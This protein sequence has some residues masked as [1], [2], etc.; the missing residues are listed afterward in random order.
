MSARRCSSPVARYVPSVNMS[1]VR[2][3][4]GIRKFIPLRIRHHTNNNRAKKKKYPD[5]YPGDAY[6]ATSTAPLKYKCH[7]CLKI[8][9][10][11][12]HPNSPPSCIRCGHAKC[13]ECP[14]APIVKVD[15]APD[16]EVLKSVAAKLAM[17]NVGEAVEAA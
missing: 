9:K 6:S 5:G 13:S 1:V 3:V 16:P 11:I 15:P 8:F 10:P 17:L 7:Q 2:T 12:P 14:R 4:L